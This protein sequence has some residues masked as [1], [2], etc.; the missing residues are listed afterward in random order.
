[1]YVVTRSM[2]ANSSN[3]PALLLREKLI[4]LALD[5]REKD[6]SIDLVKEALQE[7]EAQAHRLCTQLNQNS[8]LETTAAKNKSKSEGEELLRQI[9]HAL[10][11]KV[12]LAAQVQS[13]MDEFEKHEADANNS[14]GAIRA[15][16]QKAISDEHDSFRADE[17]SRTDSFL[18]QE[19]NKIKQQTI[20]ALEPE[21]RRIMERHSGALLALRTEEE[22]ITNEM[23]ATLN[24]ICQ[25]KTESFR[26]DAQQ[27]H[28]RHVAVIQERYNERSSALYDEHTLVM[29][30][31]RH[32]VSLSK[33]AQRNQQNERL[34]QSSERHSSELLKARA[35]VEER[36]SKLRRQHELETDAFK[37]RSK[38]ELQVITND[39]VQRKAKIESDIRSRMERSGRIQDAESELMLDREAKIEGLVRNAETDLVR[40]QR[41]LREDSAQREKIARSEHLHEL[42]RIRDE[43]RQHQQHL[44]S[45]LDDNRQL[46]SRKISLETELKSVQETLEQNQQICEDI[47]SK[48]TETE[49]ESH[50]M[51]AETK[52]ETESEVKRYE[53]RIQRLKLQITKVMEQ[54]R[55]S[56][57]QH[58]GRMR[59][60]AEGHERTLDELD[61]NARADL[62]AFDES[63]TNI[64]RETEDMSTRAEHLQTILLRYTEDQKEDR[65]EDAS[66]KD[67]LEGIGKNGTTD[68]TKRRGPARIRK[69]LK[70]ISRNSKASTNDGIGS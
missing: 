26:Q 65:K 13:L 60:A 49:A 35:E 68:R 40:C 39:L 61:A 11:H 12:T 56:Q 41:L 3:K 53:D 16:N 47:Q 17:V 43:T 30:Q 51:Q 5:V 66:E 57:N 27:D 31:L 37:A 46:E 14:I 18:A 21:V 64:E 19:A 6:A 22:E 45:V 25:Q 38:E 70:S 62:G 32:Q 50:T 7:E 28:D 20:K 59:G 24:S 33:E 10:A 29:S 15:D 23:T 1:M 58:E 69:V 34:R 2:P 55:L 9:R 36:L 54:S 67:S 63:I 8:D 42:G 44:A 52:A 48:G 4:K